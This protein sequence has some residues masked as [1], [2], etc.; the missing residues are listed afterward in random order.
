MNT[1]LQDEETTKEF[2]RA[3]GVAEEDIRIKKEEYNMC[4]HG[5]KTVLK[6]TGESVNTSLG[7]DIVNK[8]MNAVE[9]LKSVA[10][11]AR[12]KFMVKHGR[13]AFLDKFMD[14]FENGTEIMD[15]EIGANNIVS[16]WDPNEM[17]G[18]VGYGD[19]HYIGD[20]A[21]TINYRILFEN[22]AEATAPAY[23]IR[24][25]DVL[26]EN[27]F[28]VSS[29]RF[30]DTSHEA[31]SGWKMKRDGNK[32]S[33]DIEGIELPPNVN[34]PEGE[35]YVTFSV[36]LRPGLK[37]LT[38]V[39]N[40]ATIIFDY[41]DPIETNEYVNTL[42]LKKPESAMTSA[43]YSGSNVKLNSKGSDEGS[44][45]ARYKFFAAKGDGEFELIGES[46]TAELEYTLPEGAD[47][48]DYKFAVAA[49]DNAGNAQGT[50]SAAIAATEGVDGD[51]NGDGDVDVSDIDTIIELVGQFYDANNP[52][53]VKADVN[54][55][56]DIDVSDIDYVI[57]RI[58]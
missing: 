19:E 30:G 28:D 56:K 57:E 46:S 41:N 44:G 15:E 32:L 5:F 4:A 20:E 38:E 9:D 29:V 25:T 16:S 26:D 11:A 50:L 34:A 1:T 18:P 52:N 2:A 33:W 47:A 22:K 3:Y 49:V 40:M 42:D 21:K 24:I 53:H 10:D 31:G 43:F 35:G 27:V 36:D 54:H 48:K 37:N 8:V 17:V 45:I 51:A 39:K 13:A 7:L 14:E 55:D 23:R 58:K 6:K 12:R